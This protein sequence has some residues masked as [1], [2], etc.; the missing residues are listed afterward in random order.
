MV[1]EYAFNEIMSKSSENTL[2]MILS[3][4]KMY[5][6][7]NDIKILLDE[8]NNVHYQVDA[9]TI[10]ELDIEMSDLLELNQGGWV[11]SDDKRF[12]NLYL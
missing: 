9:Q 4:D 8:K 3:L 1:N 12:L 10:R 7:C 5:Q 2:T 11:L 6:Y